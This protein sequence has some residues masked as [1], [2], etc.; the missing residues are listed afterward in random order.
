LTALFVVLESTHELRAVL[1]E[2]E[3]CAV[4]ASYHPF[5]SFPAKQLTDSLTLAI[6]WAGR[7]LHDL[8]SIND[9]ALVVEAEVKVEVI[10]YPTD[11]AKEKYEAANEEL[12][13]AKEEWGIVQLKL[14]SL[15]KKKQRKK[16]TEEDAERE[17]SMTQEL[18]E[19]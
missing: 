5:T 7:R 10:P 3:E 14:D 4:V 16:Y 12:E 8:N 17:A 19:V 11:P 18:G 13:E 15:Q 6:K 2:M 1:D 9:R